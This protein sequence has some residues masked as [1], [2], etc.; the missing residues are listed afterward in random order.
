MAATENYI[1]QAAADARYQALGGLSATTPAAETPDEVG[2]AGVSTSA[3]KADHVHPITAGTPAAIGLTGANSESAG[4]GFARDLHVHAYNPPACRVYD[5]GSQSI[6]N[7][8]D[9]V[10][11]FNAERYDTNTMHDN[12]T[13]NSRI[14]IKTAGLY[15]VQFH[16]QI[17]GNT[18]YSTLYTYGQLNGTTIIGIGPG[19]QPGSGIATVLACSFTYKFAVN[20]YF[21]ILIRQN[22]GAGAARAITAGSNYS[23]EC[24]ATWIGVG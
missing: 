22:N 20:D 17:A 10:L 21:E 14:T 24:S 12:A 18:D 1:T 13:N 2:T 23:P 8:A 4:T 5:T 3:S 16:V 11:A 9:T 19:N 15:T 7:N 6:P